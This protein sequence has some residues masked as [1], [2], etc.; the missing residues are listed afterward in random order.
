MK[1]TTK[2]IPLLS[3]A[4]HT[5][6]SQ[7]YL[8]LL[9]R[10]GK[11]YAKK[12]GRN[13]YTT[14][15]A[16]DDYLKEQNIVVTEE[17]TMAQTAN[18]YFPT[19]TTR[20]TLVSLPVVDEGDNVGNQTQS[21]RPVLEKLDRLSSNLEKFTDRITGL[22][23]R[24][25]V[26]LTPV[27]V[28]PPRS[29]K[30]LVLAMLSAVVLLFVLV[31]GFSFGNA[32]AL[33]QQVREFFKNA[34]TIQGHF[35]GTHANEVL[36]LDKAGNIS[37]FGHIETE[38]QLRSHAP[39]GVA[40]L[41]VDSVTKV[42]NL[43]TD[44]L[45]GLSN[46][47]FTLAFVTKNGNITY[48]DVN[49]EGKVEVG[50][51][52]TVKGA[53]KLL[54]SLQVY[55]KLGVFSEA[56]F[57]KDVTLTGGNLVIDKGTIK[58]SN[59]DEIANLNAEMVGGMQAK[60]FNLHQ[61]TTF[62]SNT[63]NAITVGGLHVTGAS[64]F[65]RL[66]FFHGGLWGSSGAFTT[67]GVSNSVGIGD[68]ENPE[69]A[70]FTVFA[71]K[72]RI[73]D[74]GNLTAPGKASFGTLSTGPVSSDLIPSGS[75]NLGSSGAPWNNLYAN[76]LTASG[77]VD[78]AGVTSASFVIN[79]DN[80]SSDSEDSWLSF[81]RGTKNNVNAPAAKLTWDSTNNRFDIN[82]PLRISSASFEAWGNITLASLSSQTLTINAST[83]S[84]PNNLNIADT[85]LFINSDTHH[86]GLGTST[87]TTVLEVQGTASASYGLFGALQVG[88]FASTS[89]SRFGTATTGH[90]LSA[91]NDLLISGQLEVDGNVYI[92][93]NLVVGGTT[94][95]QS[96]ASL[97]GN[98]DP[99]IDNSY[100]L[101]D[102]NYRWRTGYFGTSL[103]INNGGT[104]D[105]TFEVGGTAS[106]SS[107]LTLAGAIS[108]SYTASNSFAGS[109][110]VS[111][112][113]HAVGNLTS[114]ADLLIGGNANINGLGNSYFIGNL[115]I[116]TTAPSTKFEV[117]G[118]ASASFGLFGTLQVGGFASVSY[119]RFGTSTTTHT[120]YI[121]AN[122]DVLVSGDLEVVGTGSF[123]SN[124]V[125][126]T[127]NTNFLTVNSSVTS[128]LIPF[129][130]IYDLGS[131]TNRWRSL[132]VDSANI[133]NLTAASSSISG[134]VAN[135]FTINS[136]NASADAENM[137]VT[138]ERGTPAINAALQWDSS[139]HRFTFNFPVFIQTVDAPEPSNE[140]TKLTLKGG[141]TQL[142]NDYFEIQNSSGDRLFAI[143]TGGGVTAS[144]SAQFGGLSV[145][146]ASYSR[147][148]TAVT[149]HALSA[150]SDLLISGKLEV[151]GLTYFD[152]ATTF[153]AGASIS[154]NFDPATDNNFDLG[155]PTY[156]WRTGYFGTSLG[157]N[158]GGTLD[159]TFE[160]GGTASISST[161]TLAGALTSTYTAS[162]S[163]SGGLEV[164]KGVHAIGSLSANGDLRI[165][166]NTTLGDASGDVITF[167]ADAW[168]LA[169]DTNLTLSGGVNGLSFDTNTLSI[170]AANHR[171]GILTTT[172]T[173]TF[174]V[175]G[176]ASA[177]Y[178]LT[179]N[180]LQVGGYSS[181][182]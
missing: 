58:I 168:T 72:F 140:F 26:P 128:H 102:A 159:T 95:F 57:G 55:G 50:K 36:V 54:D 178:L 11:I 35:P 125:I 17:V 29:S 73:D 169:N 94:V 59:R 70:S 142:A 86:I 144:G 68:S 162:N 119:N 124:V 171:I 182:T 152:S 157:I 156:R 143:E 47:Q 96:G 52:L 106:I 53:T 88:S 110:D 27:S 10:K 18:I 172:P 115:G 83:L 20:A 34:D 84:I 180:T 150:A 79:N 112:G 111:K 177:S 23:Q 114:L 92:D 69:N 170:D 134:T 1:K 99:A 176:T 163:F 136:D 164:N 31:G 45:D 16:V 98:F 161:L 61:V 62:G 40:P 158:N 87:P 173:T 60:D 78:F 4:N 118:T 9:A 66:A 105:T 130:N 149:G 139:N 147:F 108:S 153:G 121:S 6:Y 51:S 41:V 90:A 166:G 135:D 100:D 137:S 160:V 120:N 97:S 24:S 145:A 138:F 22:P 127:T 75:F 64:D 113:I 129:T 63:S 154:G 116:G 148:G 77:S 46:E 76:N 21:D 141:N 2:F 39:E 109:L 37:I 12:I 146:T 123:D 181:A 117:Q 5:P 80:I 89:Y 151:D 3:A 25:S 8:S 32:D 67:L 71:K 93:S 179:G 13:W 48:E 7:E 103:G 101:G 175:Q 107:T 19:N 30:R 44:F 43:N 49:L 91:A 38:G 167:N 165:N 14:A 85:A 131:T 81:D 126:G 132:Y 65:D 33:T 122:N 174:E 74:V 104:L 15:E 28:K 133:T 56:V 82:E 42:D 155:D